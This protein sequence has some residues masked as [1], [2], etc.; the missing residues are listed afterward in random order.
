M[1]SE[2]TRQFS[3]AVHSQLFDNLL[4]FWSGPALDLEQGGW[5][6]WMSNDLRV[7]RSQ[8]RGLILNTR[9]LWAFS[10]A[11]RHRPNV[12]LR[13]L[14]DRAFDYV[15]KHFWDSKHGGAFWRLNDRGQPM[16]D[17]KKI[18]GQAFYLYALTEYY[19]AFRTPAALEQAIVLFGLIE[20]HAHDP[21]HGG[22][23]EVRRSDWSEEV[24]DTRL[25]ERDMNEKKSMNNHLHVLEAYT[26]LYRVWKNP[27]VAQRLLELMKLFATRILDA[28][29]HH[30][31]HFFDEQWNV[32]S[33]TCT[34]GHDIEASWLL[35][36]TAEVLGEADILARTRET[37]L[38]MAEVVCAEGFDSAGG[39]CYEGRAGQVIDFNKEWWPQAEAAVGF[40]NAFQISGNE[41]YFRAA[42]RVWN[43]L[44]THLVDRVHGEWFSRVDAS[45]QPDLAAPKVSEWKGPYHGMRACLESIRRLD[46]I[47]AD[48]PPT[49]C[50]T[51]ILT[52]NNVNT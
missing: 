6:P 3:R 41:K 10:A 21:Q 26:N 51:D 2:E 35:C 13:R 29:T 44:E 30:L 50:A 37:A 42:R 39:L 5:V 15:V 45:H 16:D 27:L 9:I 34:Y 20:D 33:D 14:A 22:Y 49:L 7:D 18:Y 19:Q 12:E 28:R 25:S 40:L 32:R 31:H 11:F 52:T 46:D 17:S 48:E 8:P 24:N 38:K 4:P 1:N 23:L 43:Y 47:A 36:E